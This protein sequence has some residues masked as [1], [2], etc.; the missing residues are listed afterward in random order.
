MDKEKILEVHANKNNDEYLLDVSKDSKRITNGVMVL[1]IAV[2]I[3]IDMVQGKA[4]FIKYFFI[5]VG[6]NLAS[7][8]YKYIKIKDRKIL[9][10]LIYEAILFLLLIL[11]MIR[12]LIK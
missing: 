9:F 10:V 6:G 1:L 3:I 7:S 12:V 4:D 2:V 8:I 11:T 5:V